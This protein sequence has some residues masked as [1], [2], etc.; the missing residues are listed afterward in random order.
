MTNDLQR[1]CNLTLERV[2]DGEQLHFIDAAN[3]GLWAVTA[4]LWRTE[5]TTRGHKIIAFFKQKKYIIP[6][7]KALKVIN[8]CQ[9]SLISTF[10]K[11]VFLLC[12]D[13]ASTFNMP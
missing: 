3:M 9:K 2:G 10:C 6:K 11:C 1:H 5:Y 4:L 7:T 13:E 12:A 8:F